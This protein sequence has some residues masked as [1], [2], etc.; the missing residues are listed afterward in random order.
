M[1]PKTMKAVCFHKYGSPEELVIEEF[2]VPEPD[3]DEVLVKMLASAFSP[4]DAKG[5][6]GWY[7]KMFDYEFPRIPGIEMAGTIVK[8]GKNVKD[9]KE[10]DK[11]IAFGDK[12]K[13][14]AL[15]EYCAVNAG[16]C[17]HA[18]EKVDLTEVA[19]I[20]GYALT[21]AQ[22]LTEEAHV[23]KGDRVLIIG[24]AGGVGQLGVQM[25]KYLGAYVV[26]C[27]VKECEQEIL[28][29]G[30]DEF[31]EAQS[32]EIFSKYA[33]EKMDVI[34]SVAT[35]TEPVFEQY[36]QILKKGGSFVSTVPIKGKE[37]KGPDYDGKRGLASLCLSREM[38]QKYSVHCIWMTVK[39]GTER[40]DRVVKL[41]DKGAMHPIINRVA[42]LYDYKQVNYDFEAGKLRGRCLIL[43]E[44][45][46]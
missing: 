20:P 24:A 10:G 14:G 37:Y 40:L 17:S 35:F 21:A 16:F 26:G 4:A 28:H 19:A 31:V 7:S 43:I 30:A 18:P 11:I 39:R 9:F 29:N 38:E 45:H 32:P 42:T 3:D 36:M 25:A 33:S 34:F 23:L 2:P 8:T 27:D 5:R 13:G 41:L 22:A 12:T 6:N 1:I 44:N 15:A 46:I